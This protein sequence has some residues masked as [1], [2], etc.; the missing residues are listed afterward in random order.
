MSKLFLLDN[1]GKTNEVKR[2]SKTTTT[3]TTSATT[4]TKDL[5]TQA[6]ILKLKV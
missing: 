5:A 1:D 6:C 4:S 3:T 2:E